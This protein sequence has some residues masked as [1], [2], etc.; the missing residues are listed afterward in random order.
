AL[1]PEK[2]VDQGDRAKAEPLWVFERGEP[3]QAPGFASRPAV[4]LSNALLARS[5]IECFVVSPDVDFALLMTALRAREVGLDWNRF[6]PSRTR[7]PKLEEIVPPDP[8]QVRPLLD[9]NR[10]LIIGAPRVGSSTLAYLVAWWHCLIADSPSSS[11]PQVKELQGLDQA[12]DYL[13]GD[14]LERDGV[15]AVVIDDVFDERDELTADSTGAQLRTAVAGVHGVRL[16]ATASPEAATSATCHIGNDLTGLFTITTVLARRLWRPDDL[17]A[18]AKA[19]G[20]DR[21][22]VVCRE[23]RMGLITSPAQA[24]RTHGS[25]TRYEQEREW[26][27]RL[28]HHLDSVYKYDRPWAL[29]LAILGLQDFSVPRSAAKLVEP[30]GQDTGR[31]LLGDPWGI[32]TSIEV[33]GERYLRLS[34]PDVIP[35]ID[36]WMAAGREHLLQPLQAARGPARW[37]IDALAHWDTFRAAGGQELP[38]DFDPRE[39]E[40]FGSEY[41]RLALQDRDPNRAVA[42]LERI[43]EGNPDQWT[44]KDVALDLVLNWDRLQ[45]SPAARKLRDKL[46]KANKAL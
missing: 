2:G 10:S 16:L 1:L 35:V 40:L 19:R 25:H 36:E 6:D 9:E 7:L 41:V 26:Q 32:C 33:D 20:G 18:W 15:G 30:A 22:E 31:E 5:S 37:A 28:R 24:S 39:L 42:V 11:P 38:D 13:Q 8:E 14:N 4:K 43:W 45:A 46:L 29:A 34:G 44:A 17:R 23:I 12:L 27:K 21:S 3:A